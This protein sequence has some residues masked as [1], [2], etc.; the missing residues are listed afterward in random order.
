MRGDIIG[1]LADVLGTVPD[2]RDPRGVRHPFRGML[3][4]AFLGLLA[5]IREMEVLCRWAQTHWEELREPLGFDRDQP[6]VATTLSRALARCS[7]D[8]FSRAFAGWLRQR[9]PEDLPL[10]AA[11]DGKT[12]RQSLDTEGKPVQLVTVLVHQLKLVLAQW[13]VRGEKTNEPGVLKNHLA[14]LLE[15]FPMLRLLSGDA[16]YAQRPLGDLFTDTECDY[17]LQVGNNQPD[18]LDA[19]RQCLGEAHQR[20]PA[21]ETVEKRG[22]SR[23]VADCGLIWTTPNMSATRSASPTTRSAYGSIAI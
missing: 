21:A 22:R 10:Y 14:E 5:R 19:L 4:L 3:T 20:P 1:S 18:L 9:L 12:S 8:D 7:L 13:S 6:P 17:L 11:V 16:I 23:I 15:T 2:P